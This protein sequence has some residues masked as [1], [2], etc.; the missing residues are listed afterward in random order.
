MVLLLYTAYEDELSTNAVT[1]GHVG[2]TCLGINWSLVAAV[3]VKN[4]LERGK[5]NT[6]LL[7]HRLSFS[8]LALLLMQSERPSS[9]YHPSHHN[10]HDDCS[11][12]FLSFSGQ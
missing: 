9:S 5:Q 12:T 4:I 11:I 10:T 6:P 1:R 7:S 8:S 2:V 3:Y